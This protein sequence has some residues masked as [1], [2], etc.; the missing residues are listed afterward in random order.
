MQNRFLKTRAKRFHK[1]EAVR[2]PPQSE[3]HKCLCALFTTARQ[4]PANDCFA[5][6]A[7]L[8]GFTAVES[9]IAVRV[10]FKFNLE[11]G[12]RHAD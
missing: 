6:V 4:I 11:T 7:V 10:Q 5:A 1:K 12:T 8:N 2:L 9:S 3:N